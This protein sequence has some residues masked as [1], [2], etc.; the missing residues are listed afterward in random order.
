M[1][2]VLLSA[3]TVCLKDR[4]WPNREV[5]PAESG[6]RIGSVDRWMAELTIQLPKISAN[7][8]FQ[9]IQIPG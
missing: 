2:H 9:N 3:K 7:D 1:E 8:P 4:Y 5:I 6:C